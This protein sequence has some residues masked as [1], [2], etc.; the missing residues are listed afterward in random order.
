[1]NRRFKK[2]KTLIVAMLVFPALTG[3]AQQPAN[4]QAPGASQVPQIHEFSLTQTIDYAGKNSVLVKNALLDYQ[5]QEQSNRATTSQALP[6]IT[7][8][9]GIT[10]NLQIQTTVVP[11]DF[12][13][14]GTPGTF[15]PFKFGTQY[16][17]N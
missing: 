3:W 11:G 1:M 7:G 4:G 10:D 2:G 6:Q 17:S 13:P 14:G 9:A 12:I 5:I 8:S 15:V 16:N